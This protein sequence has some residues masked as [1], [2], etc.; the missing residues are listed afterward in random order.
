MADVV[1]RF[2]AHDYL[3]DDGT[4]AAFYLAITLGRPLLLEGEPGVGKTTAA[5]TLAP[6]SIHR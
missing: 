2:D 4:A 5:K 3:L 1:R 6:C